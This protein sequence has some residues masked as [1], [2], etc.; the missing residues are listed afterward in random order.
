MVGYRKIVPEG[1][2][3]LVVVFFHK[4]SECHVISIL[5]FYY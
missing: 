4:F 1:G 2:L 5:G 3:Q